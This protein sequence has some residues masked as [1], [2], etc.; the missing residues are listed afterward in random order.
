MKRLFA[1]ILA[2]AMLLSFAACDNGNEDIDNGNEDIDNSVEENSEESSKSDFEWNKSVEKIQEYLTEEVDRSLKATNLL[3]LKPYSASREVN[4]L[5]NDPYG[6]KLTNGAR[7]DLLYGTDTFVCWDGSNPVA[8]DFDLGSNDNVIA[9]IEIGCLRSMPYGV[10]L[11]RYVAVY[12]SND[13]KDY[14][15]ISR[16]TT[17]ENLPETT[18]ENYRFAFPKGI[19]ARYIRVFFA[20]QENTFLFVDEISAY[21]YSENGTIDM[22]IGEYRDEYYTINDLYGYDLNLGESDV[23][24]SESD[25]DYNEIRN[26]ATIEG[27]DFQIEHF[28]AIAT[29]NSNSTREDLGLL[30]DGV[31]HGDDFQKDYF[32]FWRGCGRNVVA[33]L[34]K[35]MSVK[36][37]TL[38]FFDRYTW[39]TS[40]PLVYCISLSENGT[41]WVTVYAE[42]NRDFNKVEKV[43]D[44]RNCDF[45]NEYKAR[46]VR[47]TFQTAPL[48]D[49][50]TMV[51]LGEFEIIG[52]K[53]PENAIT[54]T[55]NKDI[56]YG[57]YPDSKDFGIDNALF[58]GIAAQQHGVN[59]S[60]TNVFTEEIALAYMAELDENGKATD[61]YMDAFVLCSGSSHAATEDK[62]KVLNFCYDSLFYEGIN[63]DAINKAKAKINADLGTNDKEK[64]MIGVYVPVIGD[65]FKG[66]KTETLEDYNECLK[67]QVDELI[68]RFNESN[69]EN[70]EFV[71]FYWQDEAIKPNEWNKAKSYDYDAC[72]AFNDYVHS[73]GYITSWCPYY[74]GNKYQ[75]NHIFGFDIS[76]LQ[77]NYPFYYV[78]P[79]RVEAAANLAWLYGMGVEVEIESGEMGDMALRYHREYLGQG[80]EYGY[81]NA[82]T[83]YYQGAVPGALYYVKRK[84]NEFE[85]AIHE[86][87]L[88]YA[89]NELDRNYNLPENANLD[90]FAD[91]EITIVNGESADIELG[92]LSCLDYRIEVSP[93]YCSITLGRDGKLTIKAMGR[94]KGDDELKFTVSDRMG[95][96]KTITVKI[97]ITE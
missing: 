38:S 84:K 92:D 46:Y 40:T 21:E 22:T 10:G 15:E 82:P 36:G 86:E 41:D 33:D 78:P 54:A 62:E 97:N 59:N 43:K 66:K 89:K 9:D 56:V 88:L 74:N 34:G 71:G 2:F 75:Y 23:K 73:L 35:V 6:N 55:V 63:L 16:I 12:V 61:I 50:P 14:T 76:W 37:C 83:L 5:Y 29:E 79:T 53:N 17:P 65:V 8:V 27:V 49:G 4:A 52:R 91:R 96:I 60:E 69:Y 95:T 94:Y 28:E 77:P 25:A 31:L 45:G 68:R 57:R 87:T 72:I 47:L 93:A 85:A 51:F 80:V 44:T 13:G 11:P 32:I 7:M 58:A 19:K 3:Y 26:L 42:E 90:S 70:I 64:I 24:V 18:K 1:F 20:P 81:I 48:Y 67:W 39:G 30:T